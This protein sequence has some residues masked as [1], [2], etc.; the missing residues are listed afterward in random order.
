MSTL[1]VKIVKLDV[2]PHPNA[3]KLCIAEIGGPLGYHSIIGKD[4]FVSGDLAIYIPPDSIIPEKIESFLAATS[5]IEIHDHRIRCTKI[6][7][8][9][10][11]GLCL[12]PK[13]W[14]DSSKITEGNDVTEVLGIKKYEPPAPGAR[15]GGVK[16]INHNY[17]NDNFKRYT[18]IENIK[19]YTRELQIGEEVVVTKKLHGTN[20]RFGYVLRPEKSF[21]RWEKIKRFFGWDVPIREELV[22]SHN[23][24]RKKNKQYISDVYWKVNDRYK[25]TS[26]AK[27][28]QFGMADVIIFGEII[29]PR[30]QE[31]YS[32]GIQEGQH[33]VRIFDIMVNG[34]YV[35]WDCLRVCCKEFNLPMVE[36]VYRGPWDLD[37][38]KLASGID[39]YD[40]KKFVRE[41]IVIKP[42]IERPDKHFNR[43]IYKS[44]SPEFAL[45]KK[46]TSFH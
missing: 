33:E 28:L 39:E 43:A 36:S 25:L 26:I 18:D 46:N 45:D 23:T 29:G 3:D 21:S 19:K 12:S 4:Q 24:I 7:S 41:G 15:L 22:G 2:L 44:I 8:V 14:L 37:V 27:Q 20:S 10:S 5:K 17:Q 32:Y 1:E 42:T 30:V 35:D 40:G 9:F 34:K 6:R 31:G 38:V 16:G 11:E 13:D